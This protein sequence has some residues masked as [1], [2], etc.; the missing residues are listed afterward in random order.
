MLPLQDTVPQSS[1][2]ALSLL[3]PLPAPSS[4]TPTSTWHPPVQTATLPQSAP[5]QDLNPLPLPVPQTCSQNLLPKPA[6][7]CA[8]EAAS[9]PCRTWVQ[10]HMHPLKTLPRPD[11]CSQLKTLSHPCRSPPHLFSPVPTAGSDHCLAPSR[12]RLPP[13]HGLLQGTRSCQ[14]HNLP[15]LDA[16]PYPQWL[17]T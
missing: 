8:H 4:R 3:P 17:P 2:Y 15:A 9:Q 13:R 1:P 7:T 11:R 14:T 12:S 16:A 10:T 5:I 6:P